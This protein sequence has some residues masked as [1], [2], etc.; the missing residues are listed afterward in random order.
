M[1]AALGHLL[2]EVFMVAGKDGWN[3]WTCSSRL[4]SFAS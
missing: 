1:K 4:Q 2:F 3:E